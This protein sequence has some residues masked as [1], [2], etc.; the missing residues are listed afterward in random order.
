MITSVLDLS[1]TQCCHLQRDA[2]LTGCHQ[3]SSEPW[4]TPE[5]TGRGSVL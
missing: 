2:L 5:G 3:Y 4:G 1:D